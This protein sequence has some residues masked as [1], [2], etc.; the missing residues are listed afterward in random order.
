VKSQRLVA[1]ILCLA[2]SLLLGSCIPAEESALKLPPNPIL[3]GGPGWVV[4]KEAYVRLKESP[5]QASRDLAPL[6]RGSVFQV[7]G[8]DLGNP[9]SA[10]DKGLWYR[11]KAEGTEGWAQ[12][13]DLDVYASK[14]QAER[15]AISYR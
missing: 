4:V 2:V 3:S 15:A 6:R 5:A 13:V 7:V 12:E 8:R 11:L 1:Y 9:N 10:A 14:E